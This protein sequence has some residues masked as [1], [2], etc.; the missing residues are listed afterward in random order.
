MWC[1]YLIAL[2]CLAAS[3]A[4]A[5][6]AITMVLSVD[7]S[8]V[9]LA[10]GRLD[11]LGA[12]ARVTLLREGEPIVHPLTGEVLGIPEEPVGVLKI[13]EAQ[14]REATGTMEKVYS[15][16]M[17]DDL[18]E[19]ERM[20]DAVA[21]PGETPEVGVVIQRVEEL[22][23]SMQRYR[24][25]SRAL[26][27]YPTFSRQVWDEMVEMKSYLVDLDERLVHLEE[28][29]GSLVAFL[30]DEYQRRGMDE[31]TVRYNPETDLERIELRVAGKTQVIVVEQDS[32]YV[33]PVP[34]G[35]DLALPEE[36]D[37][38]EEE[39]EKKLTDWLRSPWA[40]GGLVGLFGL[41]A[42]F[43][44]VDLIRRR[45]RGDSEEDEFEDDYMED[46]EG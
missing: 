7:G 29:Q 44:V 16:P 8:E 40:T 26:S 24:K 15:T 34:A 25:S 32:V 46:E 10:A 38:L 12:G 22:E 23:Q 45:R 19:Y 21:G 14:D 17:I 35:E 2:L 5:D 3:G 41:L 9:V 31:I 6:P 13:V 37:D 11:G 36:V 33:E 30:H 39:E 43:L 27:G 4:A 1:R 28:Q 20:P 18:A 42:L